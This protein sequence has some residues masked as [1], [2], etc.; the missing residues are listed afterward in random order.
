MALAA[1]DAA[2]VEE[3]LHLENLAMAGPADL[4]EPI[5]R[6]RPS[7]RLNPLLER[8]LRVRRRQLLDPG[9]PIGNDIA[10]ELSRT[11]QAMC[12]VD[13]GNQRFGCIRKDIR[14]LPLSA[15]RSPA[16][17]G[18]AGAKAYAL[19]PCGEC[20]GVNECASHARQLA[21]VGSRVTLREH[22]AH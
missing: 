11:L 7:L 2:T 22:L 18:N 8:T 17:Q 20:I 16:P 14:L 13:R 3:D 12:F 9:D 21:F 4:N 1:R 6:G 5:G 15:E 19:G 10:D